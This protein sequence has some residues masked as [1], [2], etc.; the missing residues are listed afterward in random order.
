MLNEPT[1]INIIFSMLK[2]IFNMS[3]LLLNNKHNKFVLKETAAFLFFSV[4]RA[5]ILHDSMMAQNSKTV[6]QNEV[7]QL[8]LYS[9]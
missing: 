2:C 7:Q 6:A 1:Y 9:V 8:A 5:H 3:M 4:Q